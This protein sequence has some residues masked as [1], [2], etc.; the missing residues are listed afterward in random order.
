MATSWSKTLSLANIAILKNVVPIAL[1]NRKN[2][3]T[4]F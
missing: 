4:D 2:L 1:L 3:D